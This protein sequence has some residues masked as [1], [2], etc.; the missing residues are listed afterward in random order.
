[1]F[2]IPR[3]QA[4]LEQ[5]KQRGDLFTWTLSFNQRSI[6]LR[7]LVAEFILTDNS[8]NTTTSLLRS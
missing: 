8:S 6:L 7:E 1:M 4:N 2:T 3:S 5:D